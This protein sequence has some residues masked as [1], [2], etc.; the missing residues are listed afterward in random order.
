MRYYSST[1]VATQLTAA[2]SATTTTIVLA[3]TS[4][5]PT[6][7]PYT[8][9]LDEGQGNEEIVSVTGMSAGTAT[10][11]RG[12]DGT[13]GSA[14]D[15]GALV[16][17]GLSARDLREPQQHIDAA[18]AVHGVSGAVVGTSDTQTLTNKTISG[19][20]NTLSAI[21]MTAISGMPVGTL[22]TTTG[23]ATLTGK[24]IDG[25]SNTLT[26]IPQTAVTGLAS[27]LT[28]A[29]SSAVS[30]A[31]TYTDTAVA[32]AAGPAVD[33]TQFPKGELGNQTS[34]TQRGPVTALTAVSG[35]TVNFTVSGTRKIKASFSG[36][37]TSNTTGTVV[38]C[39]LTLASASNDR[40][41]YIGLQNF[42]QAIE[43]MVR[44]TLTSGTYSASVAIAQY[45][46][47]GSA[48]LT[49]DRA[50]ILVEDMGPA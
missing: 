25:L 46:G 1:A 14:H 4:G 13:F 33:T 27:S 8:L 28:S 23:T 6:S 5:F 47:P 44:T 24:T 22:V 16:R 20:N 30:Q 36:N 35:M 19:A 39:R 45:G 43:N 40:T 11:V 9:I 34:V 41:V 2:A 48:Y 17:H 21:P 7:Y 18:S 32:N 31:K 3:S 10:V 29:T 42:G 26:S 15:A 37:M 50:T 12:Q 49:A 38:G